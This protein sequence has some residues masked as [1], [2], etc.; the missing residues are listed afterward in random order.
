M[1]EMVAAE[2]L[3]FVPE[4]KTHLPVA[5]FAKTMPRI[6]VFSGAEGCGGKQGDVCSVALSACRE[7][8][9]SHHAALAKFGTEPLAGQ[10]TGL[11][12]KTGACFANGGCVRSTP[13]SVWY[14]ASNT[15]N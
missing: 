1:Q 2:Y 12:R 8:G 9:N 4:T 3:E 11:W 15:V 13:M 6:A 7:I 5:S 10:I 14:A